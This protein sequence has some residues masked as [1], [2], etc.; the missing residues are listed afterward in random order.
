MTSRWS[1]L[2]GRFPGARDIRRLWSNLKQGHVATGEVPPERWDWR[3]VYDPSG[4]REDK[5]YTRWGGFLEG[6]DRFDPLFF[7]I[8]PTQAELMDP[9]QRL[10]LENAWATIEDAGYRP[11]D[12]PKR[13]GVFAG[14]TT[15]TYGLAA[16]EESRLGN[17]QCPDTDAYDVAN[18]VSYFFDFHGPSMAV[19]TACSSSLTAVHLAIQS[20]RRGECESALAGGVSLTLHPHRVIQFCNKK[21]LLAGANEEPYGDGSGGFVDAEGVAAV[22]LKPLRQA[23]AD[24]DHIYAGDQR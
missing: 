19:D 15:N 14:F 13:T 6:H 10:F 7:K 20:L 8:A 11:G 9:Q 3:Q 18:R 24:G 23:L 1:V 12:L 16:V 22:L 21:M 5:A 17:F 2:A 4:Q